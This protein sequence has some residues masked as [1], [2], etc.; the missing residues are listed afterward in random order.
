[1]YDN[2]I[3]QFS[4]CSELVLNSSIK[5]SGTLKMRQTRRL[6]SMEERIWS[7]RRK[8]IRY[9]IDGTGTG[10]MRHPMDLKERI[11]GSLCP[12]HIILFLLSLYN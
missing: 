6:L 1:M 7:N 5:D 3:I 10:E 4:L 2:M 8:Y 12:L 11:Q 9:T